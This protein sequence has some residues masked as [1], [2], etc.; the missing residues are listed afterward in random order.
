MLR[1]R[2]R[3]GEG[4]RWL[5]LWG[6]ALAVCA[7]AKNDGLLV[8]AAFAL[9][10]VLARPPWRRL[11]LALLP[12]L[13][14]VLFT[15]LFNRAHGFENDLVHQGMRTLSYCD[16]LNL[17]PWIKCRTVISNSLWDDVCPPSTIFGVYNHMT[18]E[19]EM[20]IYPYHKHEVPYEHNE[21]KFKLLTETL[22]G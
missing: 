2:Q 1:L 7:W 18:A 19:K 9:A 17:A 21:V 11:A 3:D 4:P 20:A 14:V 5:V 16:N 6:L 13:W 15:S 8:A 22:L 12:L 10:A